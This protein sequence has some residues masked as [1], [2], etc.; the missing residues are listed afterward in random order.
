MVW[1]TMLFFKNTKAFRVLAFL[2]KILYISRLTRICCGKRN[3]LPRGPEMQTPPTINDRLEREIDRS[4]KPLTH[5]RAWHRQYEYF[6]PN[7]I[8]KFVQLVKGNM[9]KKK[10][11]SCGYHHMTITKELGETRKQIKELNYRLLV[12]PFLFHMKRL[13]KRVYKILNLLHM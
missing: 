6:S 11:L 5:G 7:N 12:P 8:K 13:K 9:A 4:F 10:Q 1:T 3:P 2:K